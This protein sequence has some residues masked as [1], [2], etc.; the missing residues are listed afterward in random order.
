MR[1]TS[2]ARFTALAACPRVLAL[3]QVV[4]SM[5]WKCRI[6]MRDGSPRPAWGC[7]ADGGC[8]RPRPPDARVL[9]RV[10]VPC[11]HSPDPMSAIGQPF[12]DFM[13]NAKM[14][15]KERTDGTNR[16]VGILNQR[17]LFLQELLVESVIIQ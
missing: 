14:G 5:A 17:S 12:R 3:P 2:R 8:R 13:L 9:R 7:N 10:V 4:A 6:T 15:L 16:K 11:R 1:V